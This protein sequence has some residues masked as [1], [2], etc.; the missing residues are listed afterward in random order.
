MASTDIR[1][2]LSRSIHERG[3]GS[4]QAVLPTL[5]LFNGRRLRAPSALPSQNPSVKLGRL[6]KCKL[7]DVD[8]DTP[9]F[10]D[11]LGDQ[12]RRYVESATETDSDQSGSECDASS[13]VSSSTASS[14]N[15]SEEYGYDS[16]DEEEW[17]LY[18]DWTISL[19][20]D[21]GDVPQR[22]IKETKRA[23]KNMCGCVDC[24][25]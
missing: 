11:A 21:P 15:E 8:S 4:P 17:T 7:A 9:V 2:W 12:G 19:T 20:H 10:V 22:V 18:R 1:N 5:Y 16:G 24:Q 14:S 25:T 6:K 13:S 3:C 23:S